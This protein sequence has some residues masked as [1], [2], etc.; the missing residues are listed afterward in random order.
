MGVR[1]GA[2][3]PPPISLSI[4]YEQNHKSYTNVYNK[5]ANTNQNIKRYIVHPHTPTVQLQPIAWALG[6]PPWLNEA[7]TVLLAGTPPDRGR[8]DTKPCRK[9]N[10]VYYNVK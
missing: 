6:Y 2:T 3:N 10:K 7:I 8:G 4:L 9:Y 1:L 5:Y